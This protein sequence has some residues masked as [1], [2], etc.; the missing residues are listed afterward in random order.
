[1]VLQVHI[2]DRGTVFPGAEMRQAPYSNVAQPFHTD[3]CD[4][5]AMYVQELA[6][7]GGQFQ[8]ASSGHIYNEVAASRPDVIHTLAASD[9]VFDGYVYFTFRTFHLFCNV[10]TTK[11]YL[12]D[13][14]TLLHGRHALY[15]SPSAVMALLSSTH[16]GP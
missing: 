10:L 4:I 9:W 3:V 5:L 16:A 13:S 12:L 1:M 6:A 14:P 7:E 8:I 2:K 11:S 15:S